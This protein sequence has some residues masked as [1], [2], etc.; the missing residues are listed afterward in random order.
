[1]Q[2][3]GQRVEVSPGARR[4]EAVDDV[5]ELRVGARRVRR[6]AGLP[7]RSPGAAG[8][9]AARGGG[10]AHHLGHALERDPEH[11]VQQE[12]R[13]F[14]G[15][16]LLEHDGQRAPDL[17]VQGDAVGAG[18]ARRR[19]R[20][21]P[22]RS[23]RAAPRAARAPSRSGPARAA[24]RPRPAIRAGPGSRATSCAVRRANA[25]CTTSSASVGSAED[26]VRDGEQVRPVV[27]RGRATRDARSA[28][29]V[30][31]SPRSSR[32]AH[33]HTTIVSPPV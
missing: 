9:L 23:D 32:F 31:L 15:R 20:R 18:P 28:A 7:D 11:V 30:R 25:S 27:P 26:P 16:E 19:R 29:C 10:P 8:E 24:A 33:A 5:L 2:H 1:M 6:R 4:D 3:P 12:G 14:A 17:V 22:T 13:A 21:S